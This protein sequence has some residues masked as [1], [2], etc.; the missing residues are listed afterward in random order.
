M[1]GGGG[2]VGFE[3][4]VGLGLTKIRK[5]TFVDAGLL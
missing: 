5:V 4:P 2:G 1:G 3:T